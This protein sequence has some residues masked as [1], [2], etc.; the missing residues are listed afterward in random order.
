VRAATDD[1]VVT[2]TFQLLGEERV[3]AGAVFDVVRATFRA[4]DGEEFD[5][6]IVRAKDAVA[7]IAVAP[8]DHRNAAD[9]EARLVFVSQFRPA[10]GRV[11]LELPAGLC[12]VADEPVEV[13]GH[14][15]LIEEAGLDA[16]HVEVLTTV[17]PQ[18][19]QTSARHTLLLATDCRRVDQ[20]LHGPEE[21][22][23]EV[24]EL[25]LSE[26]V[27]GVERGDIVDAKSVIGVLLAARRLSP[28][29]LP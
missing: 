4:P 13:T 8:P 19:G 17:L 14:R 27:A 1:I 25:T 20:E 24:V 16:V 9:A 28:A 10:V 3:F 11:V 5:R 2:G 6:D 7:V 29:P 18:P 22:H 21:R 15:E 23:L 12:D 26:A